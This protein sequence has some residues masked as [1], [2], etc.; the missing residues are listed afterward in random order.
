MKLSCWAIEAPASTSPPCRC[1]IR[2]AQPCS[3]QVRVSEAS[4]VRKTLTIH[5]VLITTSAGYTKLSQAGPT[6]SGRD[7]ARGGV[8]GK[9]YVGV[10]LPGS[11]ASW[12]RTPTF[13][14]QEGGNRKRSGLFR[15]I[16][17]L[18]GNN[19]LAR[20]R[21]VEFRGGSVPGQATVFAALG[22]GESGSCT[23]KRSITLRRLKHH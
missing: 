15:A 12:S 5:G 2:V 9:L 14:S 18:S 6:A 7:S 3:L 16:G 8:G 13:S 11:V 20:S 17:N 23:R 21:E 22:S 10:K 1:L 4:L 19:P